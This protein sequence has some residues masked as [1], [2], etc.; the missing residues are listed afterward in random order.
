MMEHSEYNLESKSNL[1]SDIRTKLRNL[2]LY[3][4]EAQSRSIHE[5]NIEISA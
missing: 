4:Q 2:H 1:I 5:R 3:K